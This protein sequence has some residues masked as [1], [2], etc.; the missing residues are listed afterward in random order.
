MEYV[1][2]GNIAG[3]GVLCGSMP[4][5]TSRNS[6][7]IA[8]GGV[9]CWAVPRLYHEDQQGKPVNLESVG[10][11]VSAVSRRETDPSEVVAESPLVEAWETEEPSLL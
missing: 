10:S 9:C 6:R 11:R 2:N 5:V 4:I 7:G 8:G 1:T 3:N